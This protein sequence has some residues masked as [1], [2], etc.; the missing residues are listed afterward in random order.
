VRDSRSRSY[1]T[2]SFWDTCQRCVSCRRDGGRRPL[3]VTFSCQEYSLS[4]LRSPPPCLRWLYVVRFLPLSPPRATILLA[5]STQLTHDCGSQS[6]LE[7]TDTIHWG[8]FVFFINEYLGLGVA[9]IVTMYCCILLWV[10]SHGRGDPCFLSHDH[11]CSP[12]FPINFRVS[13]LSLVVG[14]LVT[15]VSHGARRRY[16]V[17]RR[18]VQLQRVCRDCRWP[19]HPGVYNHPGGRFGSQRGEESAMT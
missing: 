1:V 14:S 6:A 15:H 10:I 9:P 16:L 13:S 8:P 4:F 2:S 7:Q 19:L 17:Y 12:T 3:R 5:T 11:I 18:Y